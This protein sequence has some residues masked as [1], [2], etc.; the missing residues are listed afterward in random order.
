LIQA[1]V[2]NE[3]KKNLAKE[4][5]KKGEQN[6]DHIKE[7]GR[8]SAGILPFVDGFSRG[9]FIHGPKGSL[10]RCPFYPK[11]ISRERHTSPDSNC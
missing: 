5:E 7:T 6:E 4:K 1:A 3:S 11:Q 10:I 8:P 9:L 2:S